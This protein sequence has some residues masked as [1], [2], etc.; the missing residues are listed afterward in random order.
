MKR[1]RKNGHNTKA[2]LAAAVTVITLAAATPGAAS[3]Q[4]ATPP[5]GL[6]SSISIPRLP[7]VEVP[8]GVRDAAAVFGVKVPELIDLDPRT[9]NAREQAAKV[10][11]REAAQDGTVEEQLAAKSREQ[12]IAEGHTPDAEAQRIASDWAREAAAGEVE[13]TGDVGRGS[14]AT[15]RGTGNI[16]KLTP[17]QAQERLDFLA[18]EEKVEAVETTERATPKRFGVAVQR[19]GETIYLVEYFLH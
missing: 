6:G 18:K 1:M 11:T 5:A 2:A 13:F 7:S 4:S 17:A 3:A 19:T 15:T 9:N 8:Q 14:T 12:L 16:Y 10:T